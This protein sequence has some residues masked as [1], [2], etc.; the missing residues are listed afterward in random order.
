MSTRFYMAAFLAL[1]LAPAAP[2]EEE[3]PPKLALAY[4]KWWITP[5]LGPGY[6]PELGFLIAGGALVSYRFDDESPRSSAPTAF[7]YSTTGA[8]VFTI[9]PSLYL[10]Q[11]QLRIDAYLGLKNMTDNYFGVGYD[12]GNTTPLG[13]DTTQY[14]RYYRQVNGG[15][16]WRLRQDLYFGGWLDFNHTE[17]TALAAQVAADPHVVAQGTTFTN[18]GVGPILRYD[19]RDF[20]QNAFEGVYF[21]AQYLWY[22]PALGGTTTYDVLDLDYR[23][24]MT[25]RRPG[26]TLAWNVRTRNGVHD[27][28]W[29]ELALLGSGSDLRG[30]REGRYRENTI[31]YG[32]LEFRWMDVKSF[33]HGTPLFGLNGVVS[34]VGLGTMGS[35]Y[36]HLNT[37]LPN[38]GVGYRIIVQGRMAIRLDMGAGRDSTG[39]YFSFNEAF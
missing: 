32:L 18:T 8:Q 35:S 25:I 3:V 7:S 26:V 34:W 19:S 38:F 33:D 10:L 6:T 16:M 12:L 36:L 29:T 11:D 13:P 37:L 14:H 1:A 23:Q 24:Y 5:I 4:G 17:A 22:R 20:P 30:Y 21:Q 9:K 27:V 15:A 28:P 39:F 2:A 31:L